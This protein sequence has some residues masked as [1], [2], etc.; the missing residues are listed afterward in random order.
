MRFLVR[1]RQ[2]SVYD[3]LNWG[4]NQFDVSLL[5]N[6]VNHALVLFREDGAGGIDQVAT[7]F[8]LR[9]LHRQNKTNVKLLARN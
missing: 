2:H 9:I 5:E 1:P 8:R 4:T 6:I 3:D 7:G